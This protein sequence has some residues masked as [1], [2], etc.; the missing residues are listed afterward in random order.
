MP[1]ATAFCTISNDTRPLTTNMWSIAG[2]RPPNNASDDLVERVVAADGLTDGEP[3]TICPSRGS[4]VNSSGAVEG[5][6]AAAHPLRQR[7]QHL[8][9]DL[10]G[11]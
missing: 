3:G 8:A 10:P 1:A 11:R 5:P 6:L 4:R 9:R 7:G 2:S